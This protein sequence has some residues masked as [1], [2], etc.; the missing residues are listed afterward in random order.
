MKKLTRIIVILLFASAYILFL[1]LGI[2]A[3]LQVLSIAFAISLDGHSVSRMYPR[4]IPFC[5]GIGCVALIGFIGIF[6]LNYNYSEKLR[7]TKNVW[8]LQSL[9]AFAVSMPLLQFWDLVFRYLQKT[10]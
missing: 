10:F 6:I 4:F 7:Y 8:T 5:F 9:C 2:A 1:S 3:L